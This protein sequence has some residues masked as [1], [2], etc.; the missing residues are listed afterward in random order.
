[1]SC[2]LISPYS[3]VEE[4]VRRH[5]PSHLVTLMAEPHVE[6]PAGIAPDRHLRIVVHD[7]AEP[8]EGIVAPRADHISDML[9]FSRGW[10]RCDPFLFHCW[11]G[12]SRSTAAAFILLCDIH[13]P[14]REHE[15]A[16]QLRY[17][18]PHAQPNRL[19][20]RHADELLRRDGRMIAAIEAIGDGRPAWQG[21]VVELA[22]TLDDS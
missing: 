15:I 9:I 17:H 19:M 5:R 3:A 8:A 2:L 18:A 20:V 12:I 13:G 11:A 21:E 10:D 14:G 1:M 16:R 7:V 6:T 4:T 22:L